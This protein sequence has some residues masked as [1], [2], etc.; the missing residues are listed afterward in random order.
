M[1]PLQVPAGTIQGTYTINQLD[2]FKMVHIIVDTDDDTSRS[3]DIGVTFPATA[4][5]TPAITGGKCSFHYLSS[6]F[7]YWY[8][9]LGS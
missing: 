2:F 3:I 9:A 8:K 1:L 6:K 4:V 5:V 7:E